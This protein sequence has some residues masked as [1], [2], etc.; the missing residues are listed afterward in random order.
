MEVTL[1]IGQILEVLGVIVALWGGYKVICEIVAKLNAKHDQ[2]QKWEEY[3]KQIKDIKDEQCLLTYCML[4]TLDGLKQLG[5]NGKVTEARD[6][7][8]RHLNK[9][10]HGVET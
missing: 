6:R 8:D 5:C 3:D 1:T 10:A 9:T 2:V 4:A 7:L